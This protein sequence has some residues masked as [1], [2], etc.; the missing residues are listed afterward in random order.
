MP[1][2]RQFAAEDCEAQAVSP[3]MPGERQTASGVFA[4]KSGLQSCHQGHAGDKH[5]D[6]SD[7]Q[8]WLH[9]QRY[10]QPQEFGLLRAMPLQL[11]H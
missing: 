4:H 3:Q 8:V 1:A 10:L 2:A 5:N 7:A 6:H 11:P 9:V